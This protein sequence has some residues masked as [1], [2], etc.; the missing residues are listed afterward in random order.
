MVKLIEILRVFVQHCADGEMIYGDGEGITHL[1]EMLSR[2]ERY[3]CE[4]G[5]YSGKTLRISEE[6]LGTAV[7]SGWIWKRMLRYSRSLL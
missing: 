7:F 2:S 6:L 5:E 3:L 1:A 4:E